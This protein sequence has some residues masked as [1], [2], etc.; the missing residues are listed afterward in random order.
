VNVYVV[1]DNHFGHVNVL[2]YESRPFPDVET[3]N[4]GMVLRWNNVVGKNDIVYHLGDF[5]MGGAEYIALYR[6]PLNGRIFLIKGNHDSR[7]NQVYLDAGFERVYD[8]PILVDGCILS[9]API[10]VDPN[11]THDFINIHGHVH[12]NPGFPTVSKHSRC[13]CVERTGYVP[14]LLNAVKLEV[15]KFDA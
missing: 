3:M 7:K 15:A 5:C 6:A 2:K 14:L 9:H 1:S 13:V 12:G 11:A 4:S 8:K 10:Y